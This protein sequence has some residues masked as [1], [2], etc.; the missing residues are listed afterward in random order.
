MKSKLIKHLEKSIENAENYKSNIDDG[1][2]IDKDLTNK[3]MPNQSGGNPESFIGSMTGMKTR[4]FYNNLLSMEDSRYLEIGVWKGSS[5]CAAMCNNTAK[6][7]CMDNFSQR[8]GT[9]SDNNSHVRQVFLN[10]FEKYKGENDALFI[11][12]DCFKV[13]ISDFKYKFN[14]YLFDGAHD[15]QSQYNAIEYYLDALDDIFIFMIDDWNQPQVKEG[16]LSAIENNKLNIV[17]KKEILNQE[18]T[19]ENQ[20]KNW[21]NGIGIF[22]L[23]K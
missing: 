2:I 13:N 12:N 19:H 5:V 16:T 18:A 11:E 6:V 1:L 20:V 7:V 3:C 8:F 14:I 4:H 10:N 23:Q 17:W 9:T 15:R 22:L 21:W